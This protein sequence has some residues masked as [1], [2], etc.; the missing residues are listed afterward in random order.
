MAPWRS[1]PYLARHRVDGAR[2]P[3]Q[4]RARADLR[5]RDPAG[6]RRQCVVPPAARTGAGL[7]GREPR[8][9]LRAPGH[10]T[11]RRLRG[12]LRQRRPGRRLR[13]PARGP[14]QPALPQPG[15]RHLRRRDRSGRRRRARPDV[16][17]AL[18]GRGQ[19]RRPG[20]DP[21]HADRAPA[22]RQRRQGPLHPRPRR[23]PAQEAAAGLAD[24]GGDGGLRPRRV[25]GPVPVHLRLFHRR[26]RGQ[27]RAARPVSRRPQRL[28]Q[29]AAPQR[30]PRP[31]RRRHRGGGARPEQ[32]RVQLRRHL[33]RLRRGRLARPAGGER[34][35]P[36]EPLPQRRARRREDPL[37]GRGQSG[38]CRGLRRGHERGVRGLR[39]RRAPR[40]LH[41]E[42]VDGGRPAGDRGARLHARRAAGDP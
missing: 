38:G 42:H 35:R 36:E 37:P 24:V 33:G 18:R 15:R 10:G 40:H 9:R 29:G 11:S 14:A 41:R 12:R 13:V 28:A 34:L 16:G 27:G 21:A 8:R 30:R 22:L 39:Q 7:L 25:P 3:A 26:Q 17:G 32:R 31:L 4:P 6:I 23:V 1:R 20:P 19:R 5:R 2:A